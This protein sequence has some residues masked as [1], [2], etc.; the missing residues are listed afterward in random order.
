MGADCVDYIMV[1]QFI[2]PPDRQPFYNEK[3][4]HLPGCYQ[5]NDTQRT[6]SSQVPTRAEVGLPDNAFVFCSFNSNYKITPDVFGVW[7][8]LLQQVPSSVLWLLESNRQA[9]INLRR[10][11]QQ[12][13]VPPERLIF[14]PRRALPDH[15]ARHQLADLFLDTF[16][17]NAHTTASDSL[18]AGLPVLT[19][20][21]E[22]FVSRVAGSLLTTLGL[23]ELVTSTLG[24]YEARALELAQH[25]QQL[26]TLRQRL[27]DNRLTSPVFDIKR[28]ARAIEHAYQKM[29][30]IRLQGQS[31]Q[32]FV[33][34]PH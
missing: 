17:V 14:A 5:V 26:V 9:P 31:T 8:R 24:E 19:L 25:P 34:D 32:S 3:L 7:M 1:D 30:S 16:P 22:T 21:G 4:V 2:V 18:W 29:R 10:E 23:P 15:L 27:H 13:G 28:A 11:A 20:S 6:I 12:R 33:I